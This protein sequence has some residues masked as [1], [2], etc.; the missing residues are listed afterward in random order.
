LTVYEYSNIII[1]GDVLLRRLRRLRTSD[2]FEKGKQIKVVS[3]TMTPNTVSRRDFSVRLASFFSMLGLAGC[4]AARGSGGRPRR[5]PL[6]GRDEI[7][8]TAEAIHQEVV[9][10]ASRKR[11]HEALTDTT[12]FDKV[13][14]LSKAGM[15]MANRATQISREVGGTF[16][17]FGGHIVGRHLEMAPNERLV[18][19]WREISWPP[20]VYSIV[21]FELVEQSGGAKLVFDHTGFPEGAANHLAIGWKAN[22]W[23]PLKKYL[24]QSSG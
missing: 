13:V 3:Q 14:Q 24:R 15:S 23:E 8:H 12:Q 4:S 18:Q 6:T 22:Y 1:A 21:K 10:N 16:S 9:F 2:Q 7:S 19:A 11:V 5:S 17:I 20:G